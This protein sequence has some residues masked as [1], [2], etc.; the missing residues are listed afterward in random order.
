MELYGQQTAPLTSAKSRI[1]SEN[2][3]PVDQWVEDSILQH[4]HP[5]NRDVVCTTFLMNFV[6]RWVK[7]ANVTNLGRALAKAQGVAKEKREIPF[8][9]SKKRSVYYVRN[10]EQYLGMRPKQI[11]NI[12]S[13]EAVMLETEDQKEYTDRVIEEM[14]GESHSNPHSDDEAM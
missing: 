2:R 9:E 6:P 4:E 11:S 1:T 10:A 5:F 12:L 13:G 3:H 14:K 7:G 8:G